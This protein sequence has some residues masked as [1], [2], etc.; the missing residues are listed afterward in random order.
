MAAGRPKVHFFTTFSASRRRTASAFSA[1]DSGSAA[2]MTRAAAKSDG[3]GWLEAA[4]VEGFGATPAA[5][6]AGVPDFVPPAA[7][8]P[9]FPEESADCSH[10]LGKLDRTSP[11][12]CQYARSSSFGQSC[13]RSDHDSK[14]RV[15]YVIAVCAGFLCAASGEICDSPL[16]FDGCS[17]PVSS[18]FVSHCCLELVTELVSRHLVVISLRVLSYLP[19]G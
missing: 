19:V 3:T 1:S 15:A 17:R 11:E 16:D 10:P 2:I 14:P 5:I 12:H 9:G 6:S 8:I 18:K 13:P 4:T 7:G